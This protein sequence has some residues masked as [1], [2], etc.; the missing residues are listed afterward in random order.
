MD[1]QPSPQHS[2]TCTQTRYA[3][4]TPI[5]GSSFDTS[6]LEL[7]LHRLRELGPLCDNASPARP[8][9]ARRVSG[10]GSKRTRESPTPAARQCARRRLGQ[11]GIRRAGRAAR[12][13]GGVGGFTD[14]DRPRPREPPSR[15]RLPPTLGRNRTEP[16]GRARRRCAPV[17]RG[18]GAAEAA[19]RPPSA[20]LSSRGRKKSG[21]RRR[22]RLYKRGP[23]AVA[24]TA[25]AGARE[26]S[27]RPT[28]W[29]VGADSERV[30]VDGRGCVQVGW[31]GV[32]VSTVHGR[33]RRRRAGRPGALPDA[34]C[35]RLRV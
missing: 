32:G 6:I 29:L 4:I 10:R 7:F 24:S 18:R 28:S 34:C 16:E 19:G 25:R 3:E 14:P 11:T 22:L 8:G 26:A 12:A 27:R 15:V 33:R 9:P 35:A 31:D 13:R 1:E 17:R 2:T 30:G 23:C 5:P 21:N 20:N